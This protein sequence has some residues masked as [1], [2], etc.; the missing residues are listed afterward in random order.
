M[1]K[2]TF[3]FLMMLAITVLSIS[4]SNAQAVITSES[5][6]GTTFVPNGWSLFPVITNPQAAVWSR[7][8]NGTQAVTVTP[9]SGA[10]MASFRSS[11]AN[12]AGNTQS[13]VSPVIDLSNRGTNNAGIRFWM[14][15]D[16]SLTANVDMME[17]L[18]NTTP[19][20]VGAV[21][22]GQI[23]RNRYVNMPDTQLANGWYHYSFNFPA[24]F[25]SPVNYVMLR[26]VSAVGNRMFVD[27]IQFDAFPP[28]C[29][30][31]PFVGDI[32]NSLNIICNGGG[33]ANL[34]FTNPLT[35]VAGLTYH[36]QY[37]VNPLS[38]FTDFGDTLSNTVTTPVL[39]QTTYFQCIVHCAY[40]GQDYF[41]N[42][43]SIIV[44]PNP[45]PTVTVTNLTGPVCPNTGGVTLVATGA[46]TY[47]WSPA[48]TISSFTTSLDSVLANPTASTNYTVTGTDA[49]GCTGTTN[50]QVQLSQAPAKQPIQI[51]VG[52]DT[53]C[54]GATVILRGNPGGGGPGGANTF[55]W[56][57]GK[58]TRNDTIIAATSGLYVVA[59]KNNAGC[60]TNDSLNLVVT[61]GTAPT[62]SAVG[63]PFH[64]C[65][66]TP[67][68][69][70]V[71]GN[72]TSYVW[73]AAPN[74]VDSTSGATIT[75][76]PT[77]TTNYTVTTTLGS[78]T[79]SALIT[80]L[81]GTSPN[82]TPTVVNLNNQVIGDTV[83]AGS[84]VVL[85]A[86]PFGGGGPNAAA[87]VWSNGAHTRRDTITATA[88]AMYIV[89]ATSNVGC[90]NTDSIYVTVVP[91]PVPAF[92]FSA[93]G[94]T[95]NFTNASTGALSYTW[96]FGDGASD[97]TA[98]PSHTYAAD[99]TYSVTLNI[100]GACGPDSLTQS[101]TVSSGIGINTIATSSF[102]VYPNPAADVIAVRLPAATTLVMTNV[103]GQEVMH[104][105]I[106]AQTT[107]NV[108]QLPAG[109][110][111]I[112]ASD[113]QVKVY[114]ANFVKQ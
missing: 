82:L 24:N 53:V 5:F 51:L 33:T 67:V 95:V 8:T 77:N 48:A 10:A 63:G 57:D 97:N 73:T 91:A 88:S 104:T 21:V 15:R 31:M 4:S 80:V 2:I 65:N 102:N 93:N 6:D 58:T 34:S 112:K 19:D 98:S 39:S 12:S 105:E 46:S 84:T 81:A 17:V 106:A 32:A 40:S 109:I 38:A 108:N 83:C 26:G 35:G 103:M 47:S 107:L 9:H 42:I 1:K 90:T 68:T 72:G 27:D 94:L 62:I 50:I 56:S 111:R 113:K 13:L 60:S 66:G 85:L 3:S 44:S 52:N 61:S 11:A 86:T 100:M 79:N 25:N 76:T 37:T 23:A 110:Y 16:S 71:T 7:R 70:S 75:V 87:Y 28:P 99:G 69:M 49:F 55:A 92:T 45:A 114:T 96:N 59:V 78:C 43:D 89:N 101:V 74:F 30:G 20:T 54:T 41:T 18:V 64:S 22:I 29:S 36:W 14:F